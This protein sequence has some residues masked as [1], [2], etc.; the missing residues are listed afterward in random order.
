MPNGEM[1]RRFCPP[2]IWNQGKAGL[3]RLGDS[4]HSAPPVF[5]IKAKQWSARV[6]SG[7]Y[8]APPV[9]GI[10]AKQQSSSVMAMRILPPP[11]LESR[12]SFRS[13]QEITFTPNPQLTVF[14]RV[15][16]WIGNVYES[17]KQSARAPTAAREGDGTTREMPAERAACAPPELASRVLGE[18]L[19]LHSGF[20]LSAGGV[21]FSKRWTSHAYHCT[22]GRIGGIGRI[23]RIGRSGVIGR[24]GVIGRWFVLLSHS[25]GR[26]TRLRQKG[27]MV[28]FFTGFATGRV[29]GCDGFFGN[30]SVTADKVKL[31]KQFCVWPASSSPG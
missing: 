21:G 17:K 4:R 18:D 15:S 30:A 24:I 20:L 25:K 1:N 16:R 31:L 6:K 14:L 11:Y 3:Q 5:G 22:D 19:G 26:A 29:T 28:H 13:R 23:G 2:R 8:S 7:S 27:L 12:Q 10:K 9:F